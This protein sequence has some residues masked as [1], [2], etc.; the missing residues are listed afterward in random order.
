[1]K[2]S[3][4]AFG[5]FSCSRYKDNLDY[6]QGSQQ[7]KGSLI[8]WMDHF[9]ISLMA[10]PETEK[11]ALA[12]DKLARILIK[13]IGTKGPLPPELKL[14]P[15]KGLDGQSIRYFHHYVWLNSLHFISNDNLLNINDLTPAVTAL[16]QEEN[17][18]AVVVIVSYPGIDSAKAALSHFREDF[19]PNSTSE[20]V[21]LDDRNAW[22]ESSVVNNHLILIFKAPSEQYCIQL[23]DRITKHINSTRL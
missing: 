20:P 23:L 19:L 21:Y 8:F 13:S 11:S 16:Y 12:M 18:K 6:G 15:E 17:A 3:A 10:W 9:Y 5:V 7:S 2:S 1:M 22:V 14:L 4:D